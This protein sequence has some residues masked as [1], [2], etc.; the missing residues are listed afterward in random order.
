MGHEGTQLAPRA[1]RGQVAQQ[2]AAFHQRA[3]DRGG[4][5]LAGGDRHRHRGRVERIDA[6]LALS[7][8]LDRTAEDRRRSQ[9]DQGKGERLARE[10][11]RPAGPERD[12]APDVPVRAARMSAVDGVG[13]HSLGDDLR[14]GARFESRPVL[15]D[16]RAAANV[17]PMGAYIGM[18]VEGRRDA[19][20]AAPL[21]H[22]RGKLETHP[23]VDLVGDL[24]RRHGHA[25]SR[26]P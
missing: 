21:E 3:D 1:R 26:L 16:Q 10:R 11:Q 22:R 17:E 25:T 9:A 7:D 5:Q 12:Q 8:P 24:N 23:A 6:D 19:G 14:D 13:R 20:P 18:R 15:D 2:L 4:Q